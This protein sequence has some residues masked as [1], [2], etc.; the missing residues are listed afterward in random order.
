MRTSNAKLLAEIDHLEAT[1]W[2]KAEDLEVVKTIEQL[3]SAL[4]KY[5]DNH[6]GDLTC[7]RPD[8]LTNALAI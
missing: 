6:E 8:W 7:C 1:I 3:K 5:V 4:H 2:T